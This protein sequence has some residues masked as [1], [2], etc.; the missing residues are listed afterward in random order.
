MKKPTAMGMIMKISEAHTSAIP[1]VGDN[2]T[3]L[4]VPFPV[5]VIA[6]NKHMHKPGHPHKTTAAIVATVLFVFAS[7]ILSP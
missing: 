4:N 7:M 2:S 6:P 3:L 5:A 1:T